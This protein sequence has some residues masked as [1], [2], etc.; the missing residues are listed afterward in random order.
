MP[1]LILE[2]VDL[3][4]HDSGLF[5]FI[6]A[7]SFSVA[8]NLLVIFCVNYL[9]NK[10]RAHQDQIPIELITIVRNVSVESVQKAGAVADKPSAEPRIESKEDS[11]RIKK[12]EKPIIKKEVPKKSAPPLIPTK[13]NPS[14]ESLESNVPQINESGLIPSEEAIPIEQVNPTIPQSLKSNQYKA[15]VR[16]KVEVW[17][18]G[19]STPTLKTSSG[20]QEVDSEVL[21]ALRKWRWKP[22]LLD[23]KPIASV[24][25][26]K[27]EFEVK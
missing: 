11:N 10:D 12:I 20:N 16:V 15:Y 22:A 6:I 27:F 13:I 21:S 25:F 24:H 14:A 26:F 8:F 5:R 19:R 4:E 7:I 18:D 9:I 1:V 23:G 3:I 17:E 2:K